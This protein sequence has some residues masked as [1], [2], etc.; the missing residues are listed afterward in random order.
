ME[1]EA[2]TFP[3]WLPASIRKTTVKPSPHPFLLAITQNW[4]PD[5]GS[6]ARGFGRAELG[7]WGEMDVIGKQILGTPQALNQ[8]SLPCDEL[9]GTW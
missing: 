6:W 3:L 1:L 7:K 2:R 5:S 9:E 8:D 4:G